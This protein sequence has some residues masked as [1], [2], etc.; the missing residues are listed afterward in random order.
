MY[1]K[2]PQY[3][4]ELITIKQ[5]GRYSLR[6]ISRPTLNHCPRNTNDIHQFKKKLKTCL[7]KELFFCMKV[8]ISH[9]NFQM[10]LLIYY[11]IVIII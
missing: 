5:K 9:F 10:W 4:S 7:F 2:A 8:V 1:G 11:I 6:S 3:L